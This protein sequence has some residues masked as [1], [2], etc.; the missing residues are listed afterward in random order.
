MQLLLGIMLLMMLIVVIQCTKENQRILHGNVLDN[1]VIT[2]GESCV[3][4]NGICNSLDLVLASLTSNVLIKITTD[5]MLSSLIKVSNLQNISIIGHKNPTVN[6][7]TGGMH[8]T[9]CRNCIIQGITWDGCGIENTNGNTEPGLKFTECSDVTIQN[10]SFQHSVGQA[11]VLS[12]MAGDITIK[13]C[14][15]MNNSHHR[16]HGAVIHYSS[17]HAQKSHFVFIIGNCYFTDNK[18]AKS[19][20]Y[21]KTT[22]LENHSVKIILINSVFIFNEGISIYARNHK[23]NLNGTISFHNNI[24]EDGTGIYITDYSTVTFDE[25]SKV[26]FTQNS[27]KSRGGAIFLSNNSV[28]LFNHNSMVTFYDNK[29]TKGGAIYSE[30]NSNVTL[31]ETCEVK[32]NGNSATHYGAAVYSWN[33]CHITFAGSTRIIFNSNVMPHGNRYTHSSGIIY[34]HK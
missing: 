33:N 15:F 22:M 34:L 13:N 21:F 29:A 25:N 8:L 7:K 1:N 30:A 32:F 19:L 31:K 10:C 11:L 20:V 4:A 2:I 27:A 5:V 6:C 17:D 14:K 23:M 18:L 16:G 9:L 28:C 26:T 3:Y 24:A 12:E